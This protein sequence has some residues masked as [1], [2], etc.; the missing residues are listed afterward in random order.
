MDIQVSK[1]AGNLL[2]GTVIISFY[3]LC[4]LFDVKTLNCGLWIKIQQQQ[5]ETR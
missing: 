2:I 5:H 4:F 1:Y 3:G